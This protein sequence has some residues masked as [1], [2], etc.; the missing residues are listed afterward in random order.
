MRIKVYRNIDQPFSMFGIKGRYIAVAGIM[1]SAV[2]AVSLIIGM[3]VGTF[4]GLAAACALFVCCYLVIT[5][6]QLRFGLKAIGR[7]ISAI[8][9]PKFI[10]VR[11]CVWKR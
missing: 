9:L 11:S 8:G 7:L 3:A 5:E 10:T 1:V 6:I 2:I 4:A